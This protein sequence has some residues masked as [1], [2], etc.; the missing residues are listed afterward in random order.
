MEVDPLHV[1][2]YWE[3][4]AGDRAAAVE[5]LGGETDPVKWVLRFHEILLKRAA[6]RAGGRIF[7]VDVDLAP[8]SWYV[9]LPAAGGSYQAHLGPVGAGGRFVAACS[10]NTVHAP[11][12]GASLRY[13]PRWMRVGAAGVR[14]AAEPPPE[15][16]PPAGELGTC[17]EDS[18]RLKPSRRGA[19][20]DLQ[21]S[22]A[23]APAWDVAW[24]DS[25]AGWSDPAIP[26]FEDMSSFGLGLQGEESARKEA[27]AE[28][29]SLRSK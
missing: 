17:G 16:A 24:K 3:V 4:T 23:Q 2:A 7:D 11:R 15:T 8:G 1:H 6:E 18:R 28:A 21:A 29:G 19:S 13:A 26:A 25:E 10:A 5:K 22:G 20:S 12:P 27:P 14:R 9:T